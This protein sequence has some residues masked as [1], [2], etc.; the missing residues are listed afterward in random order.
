MDTNKTITI[1]DHATGET[2]VRDMTPEEVLE[3]EARIARDQPELDS[4]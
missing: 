4:E 2:T 1:Y 3:D